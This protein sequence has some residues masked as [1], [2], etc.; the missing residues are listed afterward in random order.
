MATEV[1]GVITSARVLW[2][3]NKTKTKLTHR[4]QTAIGAC[5]TPYLPKTRMHGVHVPLSHTHD[6][7]S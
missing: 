5:P 3:D 4:R 7:R 2:G 6:T 1:C